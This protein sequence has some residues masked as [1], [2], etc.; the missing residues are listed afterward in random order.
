MKAYAELSKEELLKLKAEFDAAYEETKGKGLKLDMSRGKPAIDQLDMCRDIFDTINS[1]SDLKALDGLNVCNYGVLDGIPET[2]Q[3]M[4]DLMEV[5]IDNVIVFGNS[6]LTIMYD[7]VSRSVTHGVLGS[8]PWC[9]LDKVK[10]LCPTPG[11]DRHFAITEHFGIEMITI[12]MTENGPDM[13]MVEKYVSEDDS[14]KGIWCVPKY[15]NPQGYS[16]SDETV[17]RFASLKPVAKDFR[18]FWDNSYV[19]HDLYEDKKD[20]ILEILAECEKAGNPDM[21]YEFSST[22]KISLAGAGVAAMASSKANLTSIKASMAIQTIGYDKVNQLRHAR[23]FKDIA[24]MKNHMKKHADLLR[25]KF[26]AVINVLDKELTGL[27]IGEWTK[28]NGGY[29]ISFDAMEDCA[30]AIVTKCKEAGM[31]LTG[32]GATFPYG[33]DPKDSNIRIA[34]SFPTA[35]EMI[36]AT[37][38]FALCVKL[39]SIEKILKAK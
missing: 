24:G 14:I 27:G 15:S 39:V 33:K 13:D 6:S 4:A 32:A 1:K 22:S 11:Y 12:P 3:L 8:A 26:E 28:P 38:L 9:K 18:I 16:Y 23:Y 17:K 31:V 37:N 25:P 7:T 19:I 35:E 30:K 10:F 36:V 2:R 34:P 5:N 20:F 21:V 29:F